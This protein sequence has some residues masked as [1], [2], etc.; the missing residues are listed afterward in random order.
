VEELGRRHVAYGVRRKD[1][2]TVGS[3]LLWTLEVG[4]GPAFTAEA[5][6][7][8]A[9]VYSLLASTMQAAAARTLMHA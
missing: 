9:A 6:G 1:Y 7:A 3:A 2:D 4:L 5:R 8:W